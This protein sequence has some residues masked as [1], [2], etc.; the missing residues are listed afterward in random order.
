MRQYKYGAWTVLSPAMNKTRDT[1]RGITLARYIQISYQPSAYPVVTALC[2]LT[3]D[4]QQEAVL[5]T[6]LLYPAK[7][8]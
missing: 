7:V 4:M 2:A 1:I 3:A 5:A 6:S 8:E